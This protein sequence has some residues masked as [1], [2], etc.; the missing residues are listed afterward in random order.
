MRR[1]VDSNSHMLVLQCMVSDADAV[2]GA[3]EECKSINH[4]K[5]W[6]MIHSITDTRMIGVAIAAVM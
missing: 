1:S 2:I 6:L 5:T 4:H 3:I